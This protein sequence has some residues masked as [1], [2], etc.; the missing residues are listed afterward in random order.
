MRTMKVIMGDGALEMRMRD[1]NRFKEWTTD[2]DIPSFKQFYEQIL[3]KEPE[4]V[5]LYQD[6]L[7]PKV[8]PKKKP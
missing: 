2:R 1:W 3:S 5:E 7:Y 4:A 8:W 6:Q